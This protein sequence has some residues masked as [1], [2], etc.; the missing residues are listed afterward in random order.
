MLALIVLFALTGCKKKIEYVD[1]EHIFGEWID[2]EKK[3]CTTDG[4]LGHY[5][6]SHCNKDF[7][8][9]FNELPSI[10]DK[11]T[12]HNLIFN[13]EIPATGWSLGSKAYYECSRCGHI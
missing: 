6:C 2:E 9:F 7:D 13:K 4:I 5:H 1:E 3:T 10:V 12:G 11:A 8:Q